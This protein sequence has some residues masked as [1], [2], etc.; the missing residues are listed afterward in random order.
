MAK[1]A[2]GRW[3]KAMKAGPK[4]WL[5]DDGTAHVGPEADGLYETAE[6]GHNLSP[7]FVDDFVDARLEQQ[8]AA[9]ADDSEPDE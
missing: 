5:S 4:K 8:S 2:L 6:G 7:Q 1:E 3:E 9:W